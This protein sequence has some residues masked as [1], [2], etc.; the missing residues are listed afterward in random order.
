M[1][2][3]SETMLGPVVRL[4]AGRHAEILRRLERDG[5]VRV[6]D[7]ARALGVTDETI[8]RDLDAL[9]SVGQLRRTHG[10]ATLSLG[11]TLTLPLPEG[12][13]LHRAQKQR[14][15]RKAAT[16]VTPRCTVFLDASST[17][18]AMAGEI[19]D[20]DATLI[21]NAGHV[22]ASLVDRE[23]LQVVCTG[24]DYERR[25]RAYVGPLAEQTVEHYHV[26]WLFIGVDGI[27]H[28][29]GGSEINQGQARLKERLCRMAD[30]VCV[31]AD[32]SKL[33]HRSAF[34]ISP[35]N[36]FD[37]LITNS[38]ADPALLVPFRDAGVDVWVA[39]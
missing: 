21:T 18:L 29:W 25:S 17:V 31:L 35:L 22:V 15:A 14:I 36:E 19:G 37:V 32:Q 2:N 13:P 38:E 6:I 4:P 27:D 28:V 16:L 12:E 1:L 20:I 33:G 5:C 11:R 10:G 9:E 7:L 23:H 8:R 30:R 34:L 24:G 3:Q 26:E 39:D